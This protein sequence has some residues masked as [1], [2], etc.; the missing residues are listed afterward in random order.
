MLSATKDM[1]KAQKD[2]EM[3]QTRKQSCKEEERKRSKALSQLT[4]Q[5]DI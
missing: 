4:D 2:M 1:K 3:R 5:F